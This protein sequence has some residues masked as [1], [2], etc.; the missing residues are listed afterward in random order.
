MR[1]KKFVKD[2]YHYIL[3]IRSG[4]FDRAYY[5]NSYPDVRR[6]NINPLWHFVRFGWKEG[7]N[8][9]A[10][11]DTQH[12]LIRN[13]DVHGKGINPLLHFVRFGLK[14]GRHPTPYI[15]TIIPL[16]VNNVLQNIG[17]NPFLHSTQNGTLDRPIDNEFIKNKSIMEKAESILDM[18]THLVSAQPKV[19]II[20]PVFNQIEFTLGCLSSI[21][22][23]CDNANY[24]VIIVDDASTDKTNSVLSNRE[25]IHYIRNNA[26]K[27]FLLNCNKAS[28]IAQ[29]DYL[30]FLNNDTMVTD[31]WLDSLLET[32]E[33]FP[34]A[35]LVGSKLLY[36]DGKLQEAG[37]VVWQDGTALNYGRYDD[38]G[39]PKYNYL[40]EVDYCS[41]ASFMIKQDLWHQLE[42][43]DPAFAPAYY[44]DTDLAFRVR[45]AGYQVLY[46]PL[47]QVI[48]HEG[49]TS[50]IDLNRGIKQYQ[51]INH[52]K[53]VS[54][55]KHDLDMRDMPQQNKEY[56]FRNRVRQKYA[57][58]I[59]SHTP[60]PDQ[61]S[62]S[63]DMHYLLRTL[64]DLGYEVSFVPENLFYSGS[65]SSDL[66]K[67]GIECHH[68]PYT[69][70]IEAFLRDSGEKF[71]IVI[72]S[73]MPVAYDWIGAARQYTRKAKILFNTVDLHFLR[74]ER[75]A[76]LT[77]RK[78][79][80]R[81]AKEH[82][83]Q[84]LSVMRKADLTILV[85]EYEQ[86]LLQ[87]IAPKIKTFVLPLPREIPGR[88]IGFYGRR[89][90]LFLGGFRHQPNIDAV[91]Y[92]ISEIWP[93]VAK[94]LPDC[95]FLIA[96]SNMTEEIK[97][98]ASERIT[99]LGFVENLAD[100]FNTCKLSV[101]PLRYGAGVK[102]KV[103]TSLS[104]GVPCVA[105]PIAAEGTG[106]KVGNEILVGETPLEFAQA[107][108]DIYSS[109]ELWDSLSQNGFDAVLRRFST[110][111]FKNNIK[112]M[113]EDIS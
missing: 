25:G 97:Q 105:T 77:H 59:D 2:V 30:L 51:K 44:E 103:I 80:I 49:A 45:Q 109:E 72:L 101:A 82:R 11:F 88:S 32:F 18:L 8:P 57:L 31:N 98:F 63:I 110:Q 28:E 65:Y 64:R 9:S 107:I 38:P 75:A 68:R 93:F 5:M 50:G 1:I 52:V 20:I 76:E 71:D 41:G 36:A 89:D 7:R 15:N 13:P 108:V 78:K 62:G 74:E 37:G 29:G 95:K 34:F 58:V 112:E 54:K 67:I 83:E 99:I 40:R 33:Q 102:G 21:A 55:W 17:I 87:D 56:I 43:F 24:E 14:E 113:I 47:S 12:Y 81:L 26:N 92:Y 66:Q 10:E 100:V 69:T 35:G 48:H 111:V 6:A 85:S 61:D 84:E 39:K 22:N 94:Q 60:T 106:L 23:A 4:T 91:K 70:S 96:G 16:S 27:G 46:Q 19:S 79:D 73:R 53:F 86:S 3:I 104:Y 90:I 42:G